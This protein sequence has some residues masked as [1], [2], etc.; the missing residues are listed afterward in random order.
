[1]NFKAV[2]VILNPLQ[3]LCINLSYFC[4]HNPSGTSKFQNI[5]INIYQNKIN[6]TLYWIDFMRKILFRHN[7]YNFTQKEYTKS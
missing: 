2:V 5:S 7:Q 3:G 6:C 1:M 4:V